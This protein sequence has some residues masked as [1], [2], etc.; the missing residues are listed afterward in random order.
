MIRDEDFPTS[1]TN[2]E[3]RAWPASFDVVN[4]FLGNRKAE[5]YMEVVNVILSIFEL[6]H[7]H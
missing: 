6:Q 5:N 1:V 7:D 4:N 2:I 3:K